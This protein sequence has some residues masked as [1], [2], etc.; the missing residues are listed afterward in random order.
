MRGMGGAARAESRAS[1]AFMNAGERAKTLG[2]L[3]RFLAYFVCRLRLAS[4][5]LKARGQPK[6]I[7]CGIQTARYC[8]RFPKLASAFPKRALWNPVVDLL[9]H[10]G[11][12]NKRKEPQ[13]HC[14]DNKVPASLD[15]QPLRFSLD[16]FCPPN[17]YLGSLCLVNLCNSL[18]SSQVLVP[19]SVRDGLAC[20][21]ARRWQDI[22]DCAGIWIVFLGPRQVSVQP[23]C[24][25]I[26]TR[27]HTYARI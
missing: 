4:L 3:G 12:F 9:R 10:Q 18:Y 7:D 21:G 13:Q 17:C 1:V 26:C 20:L 23:A 5:C 15:G 8:F 16:P 22:C 25:C 19:G 24:M 27:K 2:S 6:Q 14:R 11:A